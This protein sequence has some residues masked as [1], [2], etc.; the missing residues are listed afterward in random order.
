MIRKSIAMAVVFALAGVMYAQ[1]KKTE[2]LNGFLMDNACLSRH[3]DSDEF[4]E[5]AKKHKVACALMP[6]CAA[7]GYALVAKG[8]TYKLDAAGNKSAKTIL[9]GTKT[10]NGLRVEVEGTIEGDVLH[11][12]H[13]AEV[14]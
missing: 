12:D 13:I 14:F 2:K 10:K 6:D 8:K 9:K 3:A 1:E 4:A 5:E 7:S 11:V